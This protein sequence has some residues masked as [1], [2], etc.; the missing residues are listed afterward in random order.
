MSLA[1]TLKTIGSDIKKVAIIVADAFAKLFGTEAAQQFAQASLALLKSA[2]GGIVTKVV[3]DMQNTSLD[4]NAKREQ[5][6]VQILSIAAQEGIVVAESEVRLLIELAVQFVKG[7]VQIAP[8][9]S[10]P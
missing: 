2:I 6:V 9:P 5:A 3:E 4:S 10:S 8:A 1:S 7:K